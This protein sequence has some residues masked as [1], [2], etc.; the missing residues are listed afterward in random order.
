VSSSAAV[1]D[2]AGVIFDLDTFAVHDGPGIRMAVYLK[3]C[4]LGC[5][6]CQSPES[7]SSAPELIFLRDRCARC[8]ACA[9]VCVQRVHAVSEA[10]HALNRTDCIVCGRCVEACPT[11]ALAVK[12]ETVSAS[13]IVARAVRMKPF[14]DHSGGGVTLTGGEVTCQ[15][16]FA[17]AIL[18]GC[19]SHGIHTA[20]ETNGACPW[21]ALQQLLAHTDL[22]LYDLKLIDDVQ[23]RRWTGASNRR[24][25]ANAARLKGRNVELRVPLIPGITDTRENLEAIFA[26]MREAGLRRVSLLPYNPAAGAKYEW[27]GF[28]FALEAETQSAV[29]LGEI[30]AQARAAGLEAVLS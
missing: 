15:L 10:G 5:K 19:R 28:P 30:L 26:F 22:V 25:L 14:F 20:I 6:W 1:S 8:G 3:G 16:E 23:H 21:K 13:E 17:R 11:G 7:I 9:A 18:A 4:Q 24:I 27:L 29:R 2:V 12:G